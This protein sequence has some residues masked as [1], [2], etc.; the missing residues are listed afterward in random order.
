MRKI[1]DYLFPNYTCLGC[2]DEIQESTLKN[3]CNPCLDALEF[4][5]PT[6]SG[7]VHTPFIYNEILSKMILDLK[8]SSDGLVAKM[9]APFMRVIINPKNYDIVIP[10]PLHK[11]RLLNRG[12]N[13]ATVLA[14]EVFPDIPIWEHILERHKKTTPQTKDMSA[15]QRHAN[16]KDAF[17]VRYPELITKKRIILVDDVVTSGATTTEAARVLREAGA[18]SIHILAIARVQH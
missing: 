15:D 11:L 2:H 1:L 7:N 3:I 5:N 12:Y 17:L 13:Q 14:L 6:K 4:A 16:Q 8:Y 10:I 9:L 18:K